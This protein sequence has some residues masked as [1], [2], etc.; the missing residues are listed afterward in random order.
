MTV[1]EYE[2]QAAYAEV[3]RRLDAELASRHL[4]SSA[5]SLSMLSS[6]DGDDR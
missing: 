3:G 2:V 1:D 4:P 5:V 6:C